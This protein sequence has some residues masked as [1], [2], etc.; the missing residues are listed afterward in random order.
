[1]TEGLAGDPD[2][3]VLWAVS[4]GDIER[5]SIY[6]IDPTT[7]AVIASAPDNSQGAYEQDIAYANG[8][9]IVSDTLG[10]G[11]GENFLDY[12][13]PN[14]LAFIQRLPVNT[15]GLRLRPR[16]RRPGW[17]APGRLVLG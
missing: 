1:M 3:G 5:G 14:T 12:Y 13:D 6:E 2:R 11:A 8:Q 9:L 15:A 7:G 10:F 17:C 4:Q 16:R